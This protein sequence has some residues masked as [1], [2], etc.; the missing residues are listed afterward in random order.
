MDEAQLKTQLMQELALLWTVQRIHGLEGE[1]RL[2]SPRNRSMWQVEETGMEIWFGPGDI[3][4][5]V[6]KILLLYKNGSTPNTPLFLDPIVYARRDEQITAQGT[7][8]LWGSVM[9]SNG[10]TPSAREYSRISDLHMFEGDIQFHTDTQEA[11][12]GKKLLGFANATIKLDENA[13][14]PEGGEVPTLQH[15][16]DV[17]NIEPDAPHGKKYL[18][19]GLQ[20]R[21]SDGGY[22]YH[23]SIGSMV[24][25]K[26]RSSVNA[27]KEHVVYPQHIEDAATCFNAFGRNHVLYRRYGVDVANLAT[28]VEEANAS[29]ARV[30]EIMHEVRLLWHANVNAG[31]S[32]RMRLYTAYAQ[33]IWRSQDGGVQLWFDESD[34]DMLPERIQ[35]LYN[36]G[37]LPNSPLLLDPVMYEKNENGQ[38]VPQGTNMA[39]TTALFTGLAEYERDAE[40]RLKQLG[41]FASPIM[42]AGNRLSGLK[43]LCFLDAP[44]RFSE[45]EQ[46][47]F[48]DTLYAARRQD[49]PPELDIAYE[50][51]DFDAWDAVT[52]PACAWLCAIVNA[53]SAEYAPYLMA[54]GLEYLCANGAYSNLTF[55]VS[56][57]EHELERDAFMAAF[58]VAYVDIQNANHCWEAYDRHHILWQRFGVDMQNLD[59]NLKYYE[60]CGRDFNLLD[61]TGEAREDL[62]EEFQFFVP[63]WIPKSATT[64]IGATGGTG[65][66]SLAHRLALLAASDWAPHEPNPL[67]LGSEI[68]KHDCK[69]L[70]VYFSGED[71]AAIVNA[72]AKLMD[73]EGRAKRLLLKCGSDFGEETEQD[74]KNGQLAGFLSYLHKLPDVSIVVIDPARKYLQ[75]DEEDSEAVSQF[76]EAIE[77]FAN[78]KKCPVIVV[79]HL[80]KEAK[81]KDTRDIVDL[82][83]GSQVFIDRPRVVIGLMRDG[84]YTV[85]GLAKNNIPPKMGMVDGER[86][87]VRDPKHLDLVWLPGDEGVRQFDVSEEELEQIKAEIEAKKMLEGSEG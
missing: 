79:H 23:P 50:G 39:W 64:I 85:A 81:P 17:A 58:S 28:N 84:A 13:Y 16:L 30:K 56:L 12:C 82:L 66:S 69:G 78:E 55:G 32:G 70:A 80:V 49:T 57:P 36:G 31:L 53:N 10:S 19:S 51:I 42:R 7:A 11:L 34:M 2:Y 77:T 33:E 24:P 8:V 5:T 45:A 26:A 14:D 29:E 25:E 6:E 1:M 43:I 62:H 67:W 47:A 71:S 18:L 48:L 3:P 72:R 60:L 22:V 63:G 68:D 54:N 35:F 83:R 65:K 27:M 40:E 75:G 46:A 86:I 15:M 73:P 37:I 20:Y 61:M 4:D 41:V 9:H 38:M 21:L 74:A 59:E 52:T 76:F 87:F 44:Y